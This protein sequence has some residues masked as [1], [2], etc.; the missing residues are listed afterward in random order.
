LPILFDFIDS[1]ENYFSRGQPVNFLNDQKVIGLGKGQRKIR[2]SLM[3][4]VTSGFQE[5]FEIKCQG[6]KTQSHAT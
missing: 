3:K 1:Q 6:Q 2:L 4:K 5:K